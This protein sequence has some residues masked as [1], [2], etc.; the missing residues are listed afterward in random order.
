MNDLRCTKTI[1]H[2]EILAVG[3]YMQTY[4]SWG[5]HPVRE[6]EATM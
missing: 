2:T 4:A 1:I 3:A 6:N 5:V